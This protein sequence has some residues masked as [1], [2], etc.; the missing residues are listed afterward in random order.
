M[1]SLPINMPPNPERLPINM[2]PNPEQH[3]SAATYMLGA[4]FEPAITVFQ[5]RKTVFSVY[6]PTTATSSCEYM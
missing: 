6:L 2:P 4:G 5:R 1:M 3:M